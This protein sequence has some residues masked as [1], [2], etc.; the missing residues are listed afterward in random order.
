MLLSLDELTAKRI[1]LD[2][3]ALTTIGTPTQTKIDGKNKRRK[4]IENVKEKKN[5]FPIRIEVDIFLEIQL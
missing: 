5:T 2:I 1:F 4:L 3:I